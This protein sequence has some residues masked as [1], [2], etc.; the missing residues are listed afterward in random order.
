M[1]ATFYCLTSQLLLC[2]Q[3]KAS[4][5]PNHKIELLQSHLSV[6]TERTRDN[7]TTYREESE[8]M[9]A[10]EVNQWRKMKD[11]KI[12]IE[13][14]F[15]RLIFKLE[16]RKKELIT[17]LDSIIEETRNKLDNQRK[18]MAQLEQLKELLLVSLR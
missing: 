6:I 13:S 5:N 18:K 10:E 14:S 15:D 11:I 2:D 8:K 12:Q 9:Q 3:C 7:V 17:K 1:E 16:T 4:H